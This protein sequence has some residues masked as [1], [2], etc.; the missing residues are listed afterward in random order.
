MQPL[1]GA[2]IDYNWTQRD[3]ELN[4]NGDRDYIVEDYDFAF[5]LI[6]IVSTIHFILGLVIKETNGK[7]IVYSTN[8]NYLSRFFC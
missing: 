5:I 8:K 3:G 4:E 6:P 2:L 7:T 1:V